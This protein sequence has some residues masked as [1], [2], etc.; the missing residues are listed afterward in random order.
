MKLFSTDIDMSKNLLVIPVTAMLLL[1]VL[2]VVSSIGLTQQ[3]SAMDR[4]YSELFQPHQAHSNIINELAIGQA[5]LH[6]GL[7][8]AGINKTSQQLDEP[9]K[10]QMATIDRAMGVMKGTLDSEEW[11]EKERQAYQTAQETLAGYKQAMENIEHA[12]ST[13]TGLSTLGTHVKAIDEQF[14]EFHTSL[15]QVLA[16]VGKSG[17]AIHDSARFSFHMILFIVVAILISVVSLFLLLSTSIRKR[18]LPT[19]NKTTEVFESIAAGNL[20]KRIDVLSNNELGE[21]GKHVN[22]SLDKLLHTYRQFSKGSVV[23]S[24]TAN[25]MDNATSQ[26]M[27]GMDEVTLQIN[28]LASASEEMSMTSSEIAKNCASA[29]HSSEL[30]NN[31]VVTG[32]AVVNE[33]IDFME[34]IHGIVEDSSKIIENLGDHSGQIGGIIEMINEIASQTNL[35]ALNAAIEAARAG[36]H[37]HGFAVV[38]DE[39]RKLAEKTTEATRQIGD[40]VMAMQSE[41]KQAVVSMEEG[42]NVVALGAKDAKKSGDALQEILSQVDV[43]T[44]E[45]HQ[46]ASA[47]EEQTATE[48]EM[49]KNMQQISKLMEEMS[50]N[51]SDNAEAASEMADLSTEIKKL[52]GEFKLVT[53]D[54]AKQMVEKAYVYYKAHGKEQAIAA[55]NDPKGEF[56]NGEL[57][58]LMM[59]RSGVMLAHGGKQEFVGQNM[60]DVQDAKGNYSTRNAIELVKKKGKGWH[61]YHI[62]NP[63]TETV[64][65]KITYVQGLDNCHIGCGIYK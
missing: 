34:R 27:N 29:S 42:E 25:S 10:E 5:K 47:S 49:A 54:D 22:A 38:S 43:V 50:K 16:L 63:H 26:M 44:R 37:G 1:V 31:A 36:E 35:L 21:M 56:V 7:A 8:S 57:F 20:T 41:I 39:V 19:I 18:V 12:L 52:I 3:Q 61:E 55:F 65:T 53:P 14:T 6:S 60:Y 48:S 51:V 23:I 32:E 13:G 28:S 24:S 17:K 64:Q 9:V 46:I 11:A 58:I 62:I 40:T 45:I 4:I 33:T 59:D 30:A 2:G 15:Q